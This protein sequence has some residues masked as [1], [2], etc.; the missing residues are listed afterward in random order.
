MGRLLN[1]A[2]DDSVTAVHPH[3]CGEIVRVK[4]KRCASYGTSPRL[5]GDCLPTPRAISPK[6]Y[7]PTLV[8][9]FASVSILSYNSS[10]HPHACGEITIT[11]ADLRPLSGTSP[12]LWGDLTEQEREQ[13]RER[14]IPTLVGRLA[15]YTCGATTQSV[16]PHA[17]GEIEPPE[18][19]FCA[20]DGTSPRLWG[21]WKLNLSKYG[22]IRYIPTLVG[23]LLWLNLRTST[24]TVHPHACGEISVMLTRVRPPLGTS[25]RL[26]GDFS[27][28][29]L[30]RDGYRYIPTLVGRLMR[31]VVDTDRG[32]VHPHA[33]GEILSNGIKYLWRPGT[34]P[35]LWGD[36][37][38]YCRPSNPCRYIPT[39]VGRLRSKSSVYCAIPVHPHACGEIV[40]FVFVQK[41][42]T[43]TS[44]RLW[45][46]Y[47]HYFLRHS[48]FR[49]IPTLVGRF[50]D[51]NKL[52]IFNAVHPHACGEIAQS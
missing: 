4:N 51:I 43:G 49:Y 6:R 17:C 12:R 26:W 16:H 8:G 50:V 18:T 30:L 44:P 41:I 21:D 14:Y 13:R 25:P 33:C 47:N 40:V 31:G 19:E 2:I 7:I 23:R 48:D 10:V 52:S 35:R 36:F 15:S 39:L 28:N 1:G 24:P 45:G 29:E 46:D 5:W 11:R 34:S 38:V 32:T 42:P 9:R 37:C 22:L 20:G 3:A 27:T